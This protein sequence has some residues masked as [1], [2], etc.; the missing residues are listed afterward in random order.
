MTGAMDGC[1]WCKDHKDK[2]S[3]VST[4]E[5]GFKLTRTFQGFQDMWG[6]LG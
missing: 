6:L 1:A 4:I 3:D 2:W 5:E